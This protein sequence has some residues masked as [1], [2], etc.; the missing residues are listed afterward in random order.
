MPRSKFYRKFVKIEDWSLLIFKFLDILY[1]IIVRIIE[2]ESYSNALVRNQL[3][4]QFVKQIAR[5][6]NFLRIRLFHCF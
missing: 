2:A 5:T 6:R 1:R 3:L 4:V